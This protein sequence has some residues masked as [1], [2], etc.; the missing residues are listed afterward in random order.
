MTARESLGS[1]SK[2]T[3]RQVKFE[4]PVRSIYRAFKLEFE[5]KV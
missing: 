2:F 1:Q 4:M 5:Y 3:V